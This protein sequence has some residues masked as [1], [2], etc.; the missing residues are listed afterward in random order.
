M[1]SHKEAQK[2]TKRED[3]DINTGTTETQRAQRN[4]ERD[5][6][7]EAGNLGPAI[8]DFVLSR[9]EKNQSPIS[10]SC[11]SISSHLGTLCVQP[12]L[13]LHRLKTS[14]DRSLLVGFARAGIARALKACPSN[15]PL[16]HRAMGRP[17]VLPAQR[18]GE[19]RERLVVALRVPLCPLCLCG[20]FFLPRHDN[21][22]G[23]TQ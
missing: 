20:E 4:A 19:R 23:K 1:N 5:C 11:H 13:A 18:V 7:S 6:P 14:E 10:S 8:E 2:G 9:Q 3:K 17:E 22:F 15:G 12:G 21:V 16:V